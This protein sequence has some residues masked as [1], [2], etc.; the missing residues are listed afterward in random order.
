VTG[1]TAVAGAADVVVAFEAV[2][3]VGAALVVVAAVGAA[4]A[5]SDPVDAIVPNAI[6]N[7]ARAPAVTRRRIRRSRSRRS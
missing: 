3:V 1:V 2:D 4:R 5:P 6:A 7:V